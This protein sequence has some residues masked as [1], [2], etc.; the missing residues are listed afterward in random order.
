MTGSDLF[1]RGGPVGRDLAAVDWA[2]TPLGPVER[3]PQSLRSAVEIM[4]GSRFA[5]WMAWG[6]E[7][8]FFCNDAYRLDTLGSKHPWALGRP[9]GEVWAEIWPEI[10]PRIDAVLR[11]GEATWD[12][13]LLLFP[14]RSGY[15][16]ETYHTFSYSP[17]RDD[18]GVVAGM[19][20]VVSEETE[21]V[22]EQRRMR[23]LREVGAAPGGAADE[24]EVLWAAAAALTTSKRGVPFALLYLLGDDGSARLAAHSLDRAPS[25]LLAPHL[26]PADATSPWPLAEL[27]AG[28]EVVVELAG[29]VDPE[30]LPTGD[31]DEPPLHALA[32]PLP[33]QGQPGVSGFLVAAVNRYRPLDADYIAF[34]RLAAQQ[35]AAHLATARALATERR[36]AA[37]L[38]E[39][40]RAKTQFFTN[41]SH[42][43][44]TPLTLIL[45]PTED[46]LAEAEGQVPPALRKRLQVVHRNARRLLTLVGTLLDF[47]RL[48]SGAAQPRLAVVDLAALTT[49]LAET[50][51]GA[52]ERV[53][54]T[55]RVDC[56]PLSTPVRVD[57]EMWAKVVLNLLSNALKY[58]LVGGIELRLRQVDGAAE[59]SVQDTGSGIAEAEQPHVFERFRR[60]PGAVGRTHEGTG[61][62][63]AL[64][65]E[66]VALHGGSVSVQ[67]EPGAGSTFR[68]RLPLQ[69]TGE[70]ADGADRE[71]GRGPRLDPGASAAGFLAEADRWSGAAAAA[72]TAPGFAVPAATGPAATGPAATGPA[73]TGAE[74]TEGERS[75]H[76]GAHPGSYA[77]SEAV[78]GRPR[79]LVVDDNDDMRDHIAGLLAGDYDVQ[80]ARDGV[81]AL[82]L[83]RTAPPDLVLTDVMM[84]RLDGLGLLAALRQRLETA[85]V[86]VVML[87]A[88]AGE[89]A[90]VEGLE[91]GADDY[92]VKPFSSRELR[93]RVRA[94]LELDRGRRVRAD[95][96]RSRALLDQAQRLASVGSWEFVTG[97]LGPV[98]DEA[99]PPVPLVD[100]SDEFLRQFRLTRTEFERDGARLVLDRVHPDDVEPLRAGLLAAGD[101]VPVDLE[102]RVLLPDGEERVYRALGELV[103]DEAG[104]EDAVA[105]RRVRGSNQ[106]VTEQRRVEQAMAAALAAQEAARREHVIADELQRSLLPQLELAPTH[107]DVA[108]FYA[109]GVEGTQVGGDWYDVIDLGAGRTALVLGDVM[110][111]GVRAAAVMGQLRS[112]VRAYARLDLSPS[113]LLGLLDPLV[114]DLGEEHI[115]TCVYAVYDPGTRRLVLANA[116]HLPP[117]VHLPGERPR[118]IEGGAGAPLG[119]GSPPVDEVEVELPVGSV[120]AL[121]TD[122]LVESRHRDLDEGLAA[123]ERELD[124]VLADVREDPARLADVPRQVVARLLP[125]GANDDVALLLARVGEQAA[126]S[127]TLQL[128]VPADERMVQEVRRRLLDALEQWDARSADDPVGV[129]QGVV[130]DVE[131]LASELV[132]NA[133][134]HGRPPL[135]VHLRLD[136]GRHLVLEVADHAFHLPR[137]MRAGSDDE[138][139]RGLELVALL[140]DRWG[141]R[142]TARGKVVWVSFDLAALERALG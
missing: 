44:R 77:S 137:R 99:S 78:P 59:L 117:V 14:E 12:E 41:V 52:V 105:A 115:V 7:L 119:S 131:L 94:N 97:G 27:R 51:R 11:D 136:P 20:C 17:L 128:E 140:A 104:E 35:V 85:A 121:C 129:R 108:S 93:A 1:A 62:G 28:R 130:D 82:E 109:A 15:R 16:E 135:A 65:A 103:A 29:L 32:V 57:E 13:D 87:S 101:G 21:R 64:V 132:T 56:P 4:L 114:R 100:A 125:G 66:L 126:H 6:P 71:P 23:I 19:L 111:R 138:H 18:S 106:D 118:R 38:A 80:E 30:H 91:S 86:P 92:L 73:A 26:L 25:P 95:L 116:G 134:L 72:V 36:R 81:E 45:G 22:I 68:V 74:A 89:E 43:L 110:G 79:L 58:T 139:G 88:R 42:E 84:P 127:R 9:A 98:T 33:A 55:L 8:T 50:F 69:L 142:P 63:L 31:W 24:R 67:S 3:W 60:V 124:E 48:E 2:G 83:A 34:L 75:A 61:I 133:V 70:G 90:T 5:M 53:G 76:A 96:E 113:D 107:L 123:L 54:L 141:V 102:Y 10:G 47:S 120:V 46:A 112:A 39:L 122:G 49:D 40:D 37:E